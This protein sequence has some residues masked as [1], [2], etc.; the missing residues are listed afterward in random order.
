MRKFSFQVE[1]NENF[2]RKKQKSN[3]LTTR[4]FMCTVQYFRHLT[5]IPGHS[6]DV[7]IGAGA[8]VEI[9]LHLTWALPNGDEI[10]IGVCRLLFLFLSAL[11]LF[12]KYRET[13][14]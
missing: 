1:K 12:C 11:L 2:R 6:M 4:F 9:A 8:G 14:Q 10:G 13:Y 7:T 3:N 5:D